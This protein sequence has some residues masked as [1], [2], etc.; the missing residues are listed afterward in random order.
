MGVLP[1]T[2]VLILEQ[3]GLINRLNT[4]ATI[5][6][7]NFEVGDGITIDTSPSM[8]YTVLNIT[9]VHTNSEPMRRLLVKEDNLVHTLAC[10]DDGIVFDVTQS[11]EGIV[12][13][14]SIM[15]IKIKK[16]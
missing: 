10:T 6:V 12:I 11:H 9:Y 16:N 2:P 7:C 3:D 4:C 1:N 5:P 13:L 8:Q 14:G 15:R